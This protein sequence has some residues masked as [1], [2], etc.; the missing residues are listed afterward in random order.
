MQ[1]HHNALTRA[2]EHVC[3]R[4]LGRT[5]RE[6]PKSVQLKQ[7]REAGLATR[8]YMLA[9]KR[10]YLRSPQA[11]TR[12]HTTNGTHTFALLWYRRIPFKFREN[13]WVSAAVG[14]EN[15]ASYITC[16]FF[17]RF[18]GLF[19]GNSVEADITK[20]LFGILF[21]IVSRGVFWTYLARTLIGC[22]GEFAIKTSTNECHSVFAHAGILKPVFTLK[23]S[24]LVPDK[25]TKEQ[26][27]RWTRHADRHLR[28]KRRDAKREIRSQAEMKRYVLQH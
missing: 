6:C 18:F 3:T 27:G 25:F 23:T 28:A 10:P 16:E 5:H 11:R 21:F 9:P 2:Y 7:R 20:C 15:L 14:A 1:C 19:I 13:D 8:T 24:S 26:T 4:K 12:A 22:L 17:W